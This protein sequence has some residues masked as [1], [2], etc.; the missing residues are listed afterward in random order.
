MTEGA[1]WF[2]GSIVI[3]WWIQMFLWDLSYN[4]RGDWYTSKKLYPWPIDEGMCSIDMCPLL[5]INSILTIVQS[6]T[7]EI[8]FGIYSWPCGWQDTK[9]DNADGGYSWSG[10]SGTYARS[11]GL[12]I[13]GTESTSC[14]WHG[15]CWYVLLIN[16]FSPGIYL[17]DTILFSKVWFWCSLFDVTKISRPIDPSKDGNRLWC[18]KSDKV[19]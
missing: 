4:S 16:Y 5:S 10:D 18:T 3:F 13:T 9:S 8:S 7:M 19:R 14:K 2:K 15:M 12:T 6:S 11:F 17:L 1:I